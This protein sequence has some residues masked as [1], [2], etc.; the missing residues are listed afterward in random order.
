MLTTK[1]SM[2]SHKALKQHQS[3]SP[4]IDNSTSL[5][6]T[7]MSYMKH[8]GKLYKIVYNIVR[9]F[10]LY[11]IIIIQHETSHYF[12]YSLRS[13]TIGDENGIRWSK[14]NTT[15]DGRHCHGEGT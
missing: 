2:L 12:I 4:S 9:C 6:A 1:M 11:N 5:E 15:E 10:K 13:L 8:K 14:D 7:N 3:S